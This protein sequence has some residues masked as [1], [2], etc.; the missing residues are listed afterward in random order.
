M[1]GSRAV[2]VGVRVR[3]GVGLG[4][5]DAVALGAINWVG[6]GANVAVGPTARVADEIIRAVGGKTTANVLVGG[7]VGVTAGRTR[8]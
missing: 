5:C 8:S 2:A 6:S 4:V 1:V 7:R 3:E